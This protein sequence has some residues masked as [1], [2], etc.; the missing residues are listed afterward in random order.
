M[1]RKRAVNEKVEKVEKVKKAKEVVE[2]V[3]ES[4]ESIDESIDESSDESIDESSDVESVDET[5]DMT[6]DETIAETEVGESVEGV[7]V[8]ESVNEIEWHNVSK[9]ERITD[10]FMSHYEYVRALAI[11]SKQISCGSKI[12]LRD[13]ERLRKEYSSEEIAK[14]E[15]ANK[16][17]PLI[18]IRRIP[19]GNV[20][21]WSVNEL[22]VFEY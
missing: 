16:C 17:C 19:N 5:D 9:D 12:M 8:D 6:I 2:E 13:G 10:T 4:D 22:E 21:R 11:R 7:E 1:P 14:M 3:E 20:E 15:I 18:I